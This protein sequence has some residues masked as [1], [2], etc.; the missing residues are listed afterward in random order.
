[1]WRWNDSILAI[2]NDSMKV[3]HQIVDRV[4][5]KECCLTAIFFFFSLQFLDKPVQVFN[6]QVD[7]PNIKLVHVTQWRSVKA[8]F[9]LCDIFSARATHAGRHCAAQELQFM[10][11]AIDHHARMGCWAHSNIQACLTTLEISGAFA[12]A[13]FLNTRY[14]LAQDCLTPPSELQRL[15]FPWIEDQCTDKG[16]TA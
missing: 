7:W 6:D 3:K 15:V 10:G 9:T 4:M 12:M 8:A 2:L 11:F 1:M 14:E 5:K 16:R 13:G